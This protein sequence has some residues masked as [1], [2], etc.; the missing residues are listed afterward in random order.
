[1]ID[2][3]NMQKAFQILDKIKYEGY[4]QLHFGENNCRLLHYLCQRSDLKIIQHLSSLHYFP[5]I[6]NDSLENVNKLGSNSTFI[7]CFSKQIN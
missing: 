3:N 4:M 6:I 2:S 1:M 7:F 5:L